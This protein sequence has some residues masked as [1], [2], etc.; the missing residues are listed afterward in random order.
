MSILATLEYSAVNFNSC[1]VHFI[2]II[3]S[4]DT[5]YKCQV[6]SLCCE[7]IAHSNRQQLDLKAKLVRFYGPK[8]FVG[9]SNM[10]LHYANSFF[11]TE[12]CSFVNFLL[13][14]L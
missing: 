6:L 2:P 9:L 3:G 13:C 12:K 7:S 4:K 10:F 8:H 14:K 11:N 1:L 5:K